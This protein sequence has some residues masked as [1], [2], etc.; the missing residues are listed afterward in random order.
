VPNASPI[1]LFRAFDS[2]LKGGNEVAA[3]SYGEAHFGMSEI[4]AP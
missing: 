3:S 4:A 2:V 1:V